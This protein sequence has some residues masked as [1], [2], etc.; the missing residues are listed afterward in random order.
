MCGLNLVTCFQRAEY[1]RG[2]NG[3]FIV[4]E[5]GRLLLD[6][7]VRVK[8]HLCKS[9]GHHILCEIM[10][11]EGRAASPI[12]P[13]IPSL[14]Q[15]IRNSRWSQTEGQLT[16]CPAS[17]L[18]Q[19]QGREKQDWEDWGNWMQPG[20]KTGGIWIKP[21]W[22]CPMLTFQFRETYCGCVSC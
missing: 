21:V 17:T 18:H 7:V 4:V 16:D 19:C 20:R 13:R 2:G 6:Q 11:W 14:N 15:I 22:Y 5:S 9:H 1:G 3:H 12:L 8:H 10:W